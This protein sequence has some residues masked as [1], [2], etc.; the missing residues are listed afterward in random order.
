M[1]FK[2]NPYYSYFF[3]GC[4]IL[5][6]TNSISQPFYIKKY[7]VSDGLPASYI[8]K[9]YQDSYGF[10]WASTFNGLSR[11]DGKEFIYYGYE[12]G[13]PNL[14][15]DAIYEDHL[16]RLWIGTRNG[17]AEIKGKRCFVYPVDDGRV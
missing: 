7:T 11:F 16:N 1:R 4:F 14:I 10:I 17:M 2:R 8:F 3:L 15:A 12:S 5:F 6:S 9:V 13:M